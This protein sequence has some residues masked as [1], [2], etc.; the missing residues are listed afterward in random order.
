MCKHTSIFVSTS[1]S[2]RT[3]LLWRGIDAA[4]RRDHDT[5]SL[6]DDVD[7]LEHVHGAVVVNYGDTEHVDVV[8]AV[9]DLH[10]DNDMV[11]RCHEGVIVRA[12]LVG[13]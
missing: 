3:E 10:A 11:A 9:V 5:H 12:V 6:V 7:A 1:R 13:L 2:R 8:L 4:A